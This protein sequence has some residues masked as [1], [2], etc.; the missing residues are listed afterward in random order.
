VILFLLAPLAAAAFG[1]LYGV[2]AGALTGVALVVLRSYALGARWRV[3]TIGL[4][5]SAAPWVVIAL[6]R[7]FP[8]YLLAGLFSGAAGAFLA[9]CVLYGL[10]RRARSVHE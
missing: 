6:L 8:I 4:V 1:A 3:R 9:P 10:P 2:I 5:A 7:D